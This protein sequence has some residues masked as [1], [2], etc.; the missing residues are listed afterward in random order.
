MPELNSDSHNPRA[1]LCMRGAYLEAQEGGVPRGALAD[2]VDS[3]A[4]GRHARLKLNLLGKPRALK[5]KLLTE[6]C[7]FTGTAAQCPG[8]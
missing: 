5:T 7:R 3:V 4:Y 2:L 1:V 6:L 8:A